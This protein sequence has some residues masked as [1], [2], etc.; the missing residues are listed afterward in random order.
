MEFGFFAFI[1]RFKYIRR[2]G[3]MRNTRDENLAEHTLE[4]SVLAHALAVIAND[5]FGK[6]LNAEK[7][8]V[9]ALY[10][11]ATET[12]TGDMPTPIKY[13]SPE[14]KNAF[15]GVDAVAKERLLKMLPE[16]I[17]NS[18]ADILYFDGD[19]YLKKLV[20]AADTLSAYLKCI[21]E[22]LA[23]NLDFSHAEKSIKE[24]LFA[25]N[26][27]EVNYFIEKFIPAYEKTVDEM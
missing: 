27:E 24:R 8:A 12:I 23:G 3:L 16:E 7:A 11:D 6:N 20:K 17:S 19:D 18:Y 25:Y 10:H 21:E 22:R 9:I 13:F 2:W 4:V 14:I 15:D 1:S 5:V 26:L